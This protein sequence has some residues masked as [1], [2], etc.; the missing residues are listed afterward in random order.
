MMT[1]PVVIEPDEF[2]AEVLSGEPARVRKAVEQLP[3]AARAGVRAHLH[4]MAEDAGWSAGQRRR[5]QA[6]LEAIEVTQRD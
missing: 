4:A 5:A 1:P 3:P 6:A 2:W